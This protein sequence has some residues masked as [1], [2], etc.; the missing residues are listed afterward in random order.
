MSGLEDILK[1]FGNVSLKALDELKLMDRFDTKFTFR[2]D[3]L[4]GILEAMI[5]RY[6]LLD[7]N[8]VRAHRYKTL[9]FDTDTL[10]LYAQ[11]HNGQYTRH[12]VRYR[13]YVDSGLCFFE[14]K[15]KNNKAER[16]NPELNVKL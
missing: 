13:S 10:G 12:K 2:R 1:K 11:H 3:Q 7:V 9:Y 16:A 8:G 15:V 4:L 14:I 5:P 6:R